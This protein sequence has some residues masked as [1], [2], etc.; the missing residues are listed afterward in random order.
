MQILCVVSQKKLQL[1]VP[2][3][4]TGA[5]SLDTA[6]GHPKSSF[7][8]PNNRVRSTPLKMENSE[9]SIYLQFLSRI[10]KF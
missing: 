2:R 10:R 4:L 1:L 7:M 6:G 3:P 8:T 9:E 5:P